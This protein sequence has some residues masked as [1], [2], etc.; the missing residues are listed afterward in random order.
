[1]IIEL[2]G[3]SDAPLRRLSRPTI[4]VVQS[5]IV[6]SHCAA[7]VVGDC[8]LCPVLRRSARNRIFSDSIG[9]FESGFRR[10]FFARGKSE[11]LPGSVRRCDTVSSN[12]NFPRPR[13]PASQPGELN[14]GLKI[15]VN[16]LYIYSL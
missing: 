16:I 11:R 10:F 3:F 4:L 2:T 13:L 14:A 1:M 12:R 9:L 15:S 5:S 6:D 8:L 7:F